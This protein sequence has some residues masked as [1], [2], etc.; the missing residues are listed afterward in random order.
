M[1]EDSYFGVQV[2]IGLQCSARDVLCVCGSHMRRSTICVHQVALL[3][4]CLQIC[5][6]FPRSPGSCGDGDDGGGSILVQTD[7]AS[8]ENT[9][10]IEAL[11]QLGMTFTL[12]IP[13]LAALTLP[14]PTPE[15]G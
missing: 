15:P 3:V 4:H 14:A 8:L 7:H 11:L 9:T 13:Y 2:K 10:A 12:S 1:R 5:H 6:S